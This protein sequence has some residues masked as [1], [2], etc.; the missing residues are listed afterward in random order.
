MFRSH[1]GTRKQIM[2]RGGGTEMEEERVGR[3][4]EGRGQSNHYYTT[5]FVHLPTVVADNQM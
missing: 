2:R 3:V 5:K 4:T 1:E